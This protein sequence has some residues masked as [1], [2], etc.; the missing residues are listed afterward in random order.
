MVYSFSFGNAF[1]DQKSYADFRNREL[2]SDLA[3]LYPDRAVL[4]KKQV[5]IR[6]GIGPSAVTRHLSELYPLTPRLIDEGQTG[7]SEHVWGTRR[8]L[9]YYGLRFDNYFVAA[10]GTFDCES[11]NLKLDTAYHSILESPDS[12][13]L[14]LVIK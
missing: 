1:A 3:H 11:F 13:S 8:L 7:L 2:A 4:A 14:C 5:Q 6:G 10:N 12:T 9:F